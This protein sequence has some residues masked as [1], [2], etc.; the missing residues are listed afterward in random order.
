M[1]KDFD[2]SKDFSSYEE[3]NDFSD[4]E[5]FE[6]FD[7]LVDELDFS[8]LTGKDF[9]QNLK[10][11][12]KTVNT[13]LRKKTNK[14]KSKKLVN[15]SARISKNVRKMGRV[16]VPENREVIVEGLDKFILNPSEKDLKIKNI[17][18]YKGKKLKELLFI[19]NNET[20]NDFN[21]ELFNPSSPLDYLFSTSQNLN[22]QISVA[23]SPISYSDVLFNILA[24]PILIPN[25][26]VVI[27]GINATNQKNIP[28]ILKDKSITGEQFIQPLNINLQIDPYQF[29]KEIVF[30]HVDDVIGKNFIPDGM[31]VIEYTVLPFTQVVICCY[32][33]QKSLAQDFYP[34]EYRPLNPRMAC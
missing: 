20:P 22:N 30:F 26:K 10:A 27:T 24:N 28:L 18:Y 16:L 13:K 29:Q 3:F 12:N 14:N 1:E 4:L 2:Y 15:K 6:N 31:N 34:T 25:V 33:E 7:S 11:V 23:N 32:Y 19:I 21:I 17:G 9:K 5:T 8:L